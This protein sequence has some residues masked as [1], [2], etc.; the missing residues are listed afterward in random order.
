MNPLGPIANIAIHFL[1]FFIAMFGLTALNYEKALRQ[2]KVAQAQVL[3]IACSMALG[4]L[5][6][7]FLIQLLIP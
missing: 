2:G 1:G 3:Y 7:Q 5:I 6:A 4:Y